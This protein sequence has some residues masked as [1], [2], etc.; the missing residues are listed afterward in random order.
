MLIAT[1]PGS[2]RT[3]RRHCRGT[4]PN[5]WRMQLNPSKCPV[6]PPHGC[7]ISL[8]TSTAR[9]KGG[10]QGYPLR[11]STLAVVDQHRPYP[12]PLPAGSLRPPER[13][14]PS[15]ERGAGPHPGRQ[16]SRG[17]LSGEVPSCLTLVSSSDLD[18]V[19]AKGGHALAASICVGT[20]ACAVTKPIEQIPGARLAEVV[21]KGAMHWLPICVGTAARAVAK[22][23][24]QIPGARLLPCRNPHH[25]RTSL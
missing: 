16:A 11:A 21:T 7:P 14:P 3:T 9:V 10:L 24:E 20:A 18:K 15:G 17:K 6:G 5:A 12:H 23:I 8:V 4:N 22:P 19:P 1:L 13:S 2:E 25:V